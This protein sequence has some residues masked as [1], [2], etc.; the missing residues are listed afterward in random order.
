MVTQGRYGIIP[1]MGISFER[2]SK[3]FRPQ[4]GVEKL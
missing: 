1:G 4:N 2:I 3:L